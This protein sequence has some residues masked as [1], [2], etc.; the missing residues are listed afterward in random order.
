[1]DKLELIISISFP[2]L[3]IFFGGC[4]IYKNLNKTDHNP[5]EGDDYRNQ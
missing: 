1:M 3:V 5:H 4:L 2:L